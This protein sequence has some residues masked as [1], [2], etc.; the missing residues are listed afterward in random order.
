M[1]TAVPGVRVGHWDDVRALTGCTVILSPAGT[2]GSVFV[3]GGAPA[4]HETDALAPGRLVH[5]V[6]AVVLT[7]GSAF[8]LATTAGVMWWLEARGIGHATP[9]G[10]V[11][12][13]PAAAIYDLSIGDA[14]VR[15]GPADA[16]AACIAARD[17]DTREGSVGAGM[18]ATVGKLAGF[19][20]QA[21]G[22]LGQA[23]RVD[24]DLIV[25]ALAVCN[26]L[27]DVID[28]DGSI[29]A[30]ARAEPLDLPPPSAATT[31]ACVATNARLTR[32]ECYEVARAAAGGLA[33][34]VRPVYTMFDG[35]TVFA[36]ATAGVASSVDVVGALAADALAEAVRRG[37]R[38]ATS[39]P[40]AP[41]R[42]HR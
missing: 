24:G 7:G 14:S 6:H 2:T 31:I 18:G 29:I 27:G 28:D 11:P 21:R 13:V 41:A 8:G 32:D 22:G 16:E 12:I 33:R 39:V 38:A 17:D 4:T 9:A 1:I 20:N 35:D 23:A 30:G 40:G 42:A 34:A 37:V 3:A 26:A 25:A 15:P 19:E 5:Q 36:L 10:P